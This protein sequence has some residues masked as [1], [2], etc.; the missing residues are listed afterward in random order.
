[1]TNRPTDEE[2]DRCER[3]LTDCT[4]HPDY[5]RLRMA[6]PDCMAC[7]LGS[8]II[9]TFRAM[10]ATIQSISTIK[11]YDMALTETDIPYMDETPNGT[12]VRFDDLP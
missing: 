12:Y 6:D 2:M 8:E 4:C 1:M 3:M 7:Q 9:D 11:R 10:R 5:Q